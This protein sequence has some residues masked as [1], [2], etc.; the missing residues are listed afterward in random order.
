MVK[1]AEKMALEN[2]IGA[3]DISPENRELVRESVVEFS[4][5]IREGSRHANLLMSEIDTMV[6][7]LDL[8]TSFMVK[9][10]ES[11]EVDKIEVEPSD[12]VALESLVSGLANRYH[13]LDLLEVKTVIAL[14]NFQ[15]P[16]ALQR[17]RFN[18]A[19]EGLGQVVDKITRKIVDF[20]MAAIRWV[21]DLYKDN[22]TVLGSLETSIASMEVTLRKNGVRNESGRIPAKGRI[23]SSFGYL[24]KDINSKDV[25]N[26]VSSF[27]SVYE[28]IESALKEVT[29][30]IEDQVN[31]VSGDDLS[32][33]INDP[34][35]LNFNTEGFLRLGND[36][37]AVPPG[38]YPE[39]TVQFR[40]A[41]G[42]K[43]TNNVLLEL[44]K[45]EY[46]D[47]DFSVIVDNASSL[48]KVTAELNHIIVSIKTI[49]KE[50]KNR[51]V[52]I[53]RSIRKIER[54]LTTVAK[55]AKDK[56]A[57]KEIRQLTN[58]LRSITRFYVSLN[59][60]YVTYAKG[61]LKA[62]Y[63]F[64]DVCQSSKPEKK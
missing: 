18:F 2:R 3:I 13:D 54:N 4:E 32:N 55:K 56:N 26:A 62:G 46:V 5:K 59:R 43:K 14:E 33:K 53:E 17:Q 58:S 10:K 61:A 21:T 6:G 35:F 27:S 16:P 7:D 24:S 57:L 63:D 34:D 64:V 48:L 47:S 15:C 38:L 19:M 52:I 36:K 60:S 31:I 1:L 41:G 45:V 9:V 49:G 50:S 40:E 51:G 30:L 12:I 42:G 8:L 25:L 22:F 44:K 20:I 37:S 39:V 11:Q 28:T 23:K 29:K